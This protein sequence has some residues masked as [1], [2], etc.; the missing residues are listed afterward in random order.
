MGHKYK[1]GVKSLAIVFADQ[2]L[3]ESQGITC[4]PEG[5]FIGDFNKFVLSELW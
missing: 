2:A 1:P 4:I 5:A 3:Q